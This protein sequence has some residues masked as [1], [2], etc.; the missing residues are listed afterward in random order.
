ME[1]EATTTFLKGGYFTTAVNLP[2]NLR[3]VVL[4]SIYFSTRHW[5][6]TLSNGTRPAD[7]SGV[8]V[9]LEGVLSAAKANNE[10]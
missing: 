8:F 3:V 9:W 2:A 4:N 7:P 10:L 1:A 6:E 5:P